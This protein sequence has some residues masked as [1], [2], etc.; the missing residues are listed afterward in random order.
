MEFISL[1]EFLAI[2]DGVIE[3]LSGQSWLKRY[4]IAKK[5]FEDYGDKPPVGSLV[6]TLRPG[7]GG[8]SGVHLTLNGVFK[9]DERYFELARNDGVSISLRKTWWRDFRIV[10]EKPNGTVI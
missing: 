8:W 5:S 10:K 2:N 4:E 1:A 6:E 3:S 9:R 7:F